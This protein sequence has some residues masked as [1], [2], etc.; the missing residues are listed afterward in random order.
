MTEDMEPSAADR[1]LDRSRRALQA[2][3]AIAALLPV[4]AGAAGVLVGPR[5]LGAGAPPSADLD[6]HVRFLSG[7]FFVV[8]LAWWTCI[9]GIERKGGRLRLLALMTFAGGLARLLSFV[10]AGAPSAGHMVGLTMELVGVPLV[11]IWQATIARGGW[12]GPR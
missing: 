1:R 5:F 7:V 8:G 6:S 11:V 4:F 2:F 9:P 10:V 12:R 3:V